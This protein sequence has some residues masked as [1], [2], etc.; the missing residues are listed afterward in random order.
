MKNLHSS[1]VWEDG[2]SRLACLLLICV[3]FAPTQLADWLT[4]SRLF[5]W[6]SKSF[7]AHLPLDHAGQPDLLDLADLKRAR[8]GGERAR[9]HCVTGR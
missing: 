4:I 9:G 7:T 8:V 5:R 2:Q 6:S 3:Q 1:F